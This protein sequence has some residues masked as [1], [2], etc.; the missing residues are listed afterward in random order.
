MKESDI[1]SLFPVVE[2]AVTGA[3]VVKCTIRPLKAATGVDSKVAED[4]EEQIVNGAIHKLLMMP[5]KP[6]S[7][8]KLGM[9]Y[10][11]MFRNGCMTA[12]ARVNKG[13]TD[14]SLQVG[15]QKIVPTSISIRRVV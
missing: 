9:F 8:P 11:K 3:I 7:N 12:R 10:G 14:A 1:V 13:F 5:D 15:F 4:Y 2:T 6:W